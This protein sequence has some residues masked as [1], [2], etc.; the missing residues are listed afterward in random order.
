METFKEN[1]LQGLKEKSHLFADIMSSQHTLNIFLQLVEYF[2]K[3]TVRNKNA[4]N[5]LLS[6]ICSYLVH[7]M[8]LKQHL[9]N[10]VHRRFVEIYNHSIL[11]RST[12]KGNPFL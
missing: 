2:I 4:L 8:L 10:R 6:A 11:K 1:L 7:N 9:E 12:H 5:F 3:K